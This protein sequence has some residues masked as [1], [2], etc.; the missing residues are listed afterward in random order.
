MARYELLAP[1]LHD[2]V[3]LAQVAAAQADDGVT[4]R[5]MQR[6]LADCRREGLDGLARR[7]RSDK[8]CADCPRS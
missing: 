2:G 4:Y 5:T 3:S 6:W 7:G 1:H 8:G